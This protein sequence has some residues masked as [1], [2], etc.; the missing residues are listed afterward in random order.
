[1]EDRAFS[2]APSPHKGASVLRMEDVNMRNEESNIGDDD[3]S[4]ECIASAARGQHTHSRHENLQEREYEQLQRDLKKMNGTKTKIHEDLGHLQRYPLSVTIDEEY[5]HGMARSKT[6]GREIMRTEEMFVVD[7]DNDDYQK[8]IPALVNTL[9]KLVNR[10]D[11]LNH[12]LQIGKMF[13]CSHACCHENCNYKGDSTSCANIR[14]F[15]DDNKYNIIESEHYGTHGTIDGAVDINMKDTGVQDV[16]QEIKRESKTSASSFMS[17]SQSNPANILKQETQTEIIGKLA[18]QSSSNGANQTVLNNRK[19][20]QIRNV[21]DKMVHQGDHSSSVKTVPIDLSG[22]K[23]VQTDQRDDNRK[24]DIKAERDFGI[25]KDA[26]FTGEPLTNTNFINRH[27]PKLKKTEALHPKRE[28]TYLDGQTKEVNSSMTSLQVP[29]HIKEEEKGVKTGRS[30]DQDRQTEGS[31]TMSASQTTQTVRRTD[32][33]IVMLNEVPQEY[34]HSVIH[35]AYEEAKTLETARSKG[36]HTIICVDTSMSMSE[37]W[38]DILEFLRNFINEI[39]KM[40]SIDVELVEHIAV[41]TFGL[42]TCVLQHF[43]TNYQEVLTKLHLVKPEGSTPM[44]WGLCLCKAIL[45]GSAKRNR[46]HPRYLLITDGRPTYRFW[47]SGSDVP[48]KDYEEMEKKDAARE[49]IKI[50]FRSPIFKVYPVAVG[51]NCDMEFSSAIADSSRGKVMN[52]SD[53]KE[54]AHY[55]KKVEFALQYFHLASLSEEF[56]A[57]WIKKKSCLLQEDIEFINKV[58]TDEMEHQNN[59]GTTSDEKKVVG[60]YQFPPVG[61]RVRRGPD[62]NRKDEDNDGPGTLITYCKGIAFSGWVIVHWDK[63]KK[64]RRWLFRYRYG[65]QNAYDI[66]VQANDEPRVTKSRFNIIIGCEVVKGRY[67]KSTDDIEEGTI[68]MVYNIRHNENGES[69]A[70]VRWQNGKRLKYGERCLLVG[71]IDISPRSRPNPLPSLPSPHP[72]ISHHTSMDISIQDL[73]RSEGVLPSRGRSLL[74]SSGGHS[75]SKKHQCSEENSGSVAAG[76]RVA[77][78]IENVER[79]GMPSIDDMN[80]RNQILLRKKKASSTQSVG[81]TRN[82][83]DF[84]T[85]DRHNATEDAGSYGNSTRHRPKRSNKNSHVK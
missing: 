46:L 3:T 23:R 76:D 66:T 57:R 24:R 72:G 10:M 30:D 71:E 83:S 25:N 22:L 43:T 4:D 78:T 29:D 63:P 18:G 26:K 74:P 38:G 12:R 21:H 85:T 35:D 67:R 27:K 6:R 34:W 55:G 75:S 58:V 79:Y 42:Q 49:L 20:I 81:I 53:W 7:N 11:T 41:V 17:Q 56:F 82:S 15:I 5:M 52:L 14:E 61:S 31:D 1:M 48:V 54:I 84:V 47:T 65:A 59:E 77:F 37:Y 13:V 80:S 69:I 19:E 68:G 40:Q 28:T 73:I 62:W 2:T 60:S 8:K 50:K 44:H 45:Y 64:Y 32:Q 51:N 16:P 33:P 9:N 39:C 36:L 70:K